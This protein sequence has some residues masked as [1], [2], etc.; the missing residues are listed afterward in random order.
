M[1]AL[2]AIAILATLGFYLPALT[3]S[4]RKL[5]AAVQ[6]EIAGMMKM[7]KDVGGKPMPSPGLLTIADLTGDPFPDFVVD[8]SAFVCDGAASLFAGS[9]GSQVS[10]YVGTQNGQ[11]TEA[12]SSGTFGIKIDKD[13]KPAKV[14]LVVGGPLCGQKVTSK[15]P[16]AAYKNCW[17]PLVWS[18]AAKKMEFAP[19]SA[20]EPFK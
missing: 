14:K 10:V 18:A 11:A 1:N 20:I 7:C 9:G 13:A 4:Q 19:L 17:R 2:R 16:M 8:Q 12:F 6:Q 15:T 5:P 3:Q